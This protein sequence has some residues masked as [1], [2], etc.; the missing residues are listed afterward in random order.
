MP[1]L[2]TTMYNGYTLTYTSQ[3]ESVIIKHDGKKVKVEPNLEKAKAWVNK[4]PGSY[5]KGEKKVGTSMA[6]SISVKLAAAKAALNKKQ[7]DLDAIDD[8]IMGLDSALPPDA[9]ATPEFDLLTAKREELEEEIRTMREGVQFI[10]EWEKLKGGQWSE[11]IKSQLD[12]LDS[13]IANIAGGNPEAGASAPFLSSDPLDPLAPAPDAPPAPDAVSAPSEPLAPEAPAAV[14]PAPEASAPALEPPMASASSKK[15]NYQSHQ[16]KGNSAP[17]EAKEGLKMANQTATKP[18]IKEKLAELKQK[19]AAIQKEAQVRT[20]AAYTI[21]NTMLPGAPVEKRQAFASA[22]LQ[23]NDTKTLVAALRQTAVN[24]HYSKVAEQFKEVHKVEMNDLLEDPSVLKQERAAVEKEIKGEAK[25]AGKTADDRKDAGPQTDTYNDGRGHGGGTESEPKAMDAG[26]K[27]SQTE[28]AGRPMDTINKSEGDK[29]KKE[30]AAKTAHGKDCKGCAD[31][32]KSKKEAAE[33]CADCKDDK[34]CSKHASAKKA[35]EPAMDAPAMDEPIAEE[36]MAEAPMGDEAPMTDAPMEAE[37]PADDAGAILTDEK[38]MVVEEKI[39][40]AQ[41]AIKALE[42]ELLE[43]NE[44]EPALALEE[45]GAPSEPSEEELD[46][47]SVFDQG[48]MEDKAASLANEGEEHT[49]AEDFFAPTSA[50]GMESVLDDSGMQTA[51]IEDYFSMQGAEAD[52]LYSLIASEDKV[53][54]NV[55]GTDVLE[56]FTGE[57]ANKMKQHEA[58]PDGR[59]SEA[60]H[61]EDLFAEAMK[62]IKPEEQGAKRTPQD[63]VPELQAPKSAAKTAGKGSIKRVRPVVAS[64]KPVDIASALFGDE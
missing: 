6:K 3:H 57:V 35:D 60:D 20:A 40:E 56:S 54:A 14:E 19:R 58:G 21:A 37:A 30:A 15:S 24:A 12:S 62:D 47:S 18:S 5:S 26:S 42:Q 23:G 33:K 61:D 36:P 38:K 27:E 41:E 29:A 10:S 17:S 9:L 7:A 11:G 28:A 1:D 52:P 50:A 16:K 13:E 59:D 55:D 53:A 48:E 8:Q 34:K 4:A 44:E 2:K 25:A 46:L 31:C 45:E 43:E 22:L 63:S 32:D 51:S 39:E 64:P 49:A